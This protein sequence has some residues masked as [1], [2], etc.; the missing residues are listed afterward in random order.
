[1]QATITALL[2]TCVFVGVTASATAQVIYR[3]TTDLPDGG[4]IPDGNAAGWSDT[5]TLSG[6]PAIGLR[7]V[8]VVLSL[9]GGYNGDLYGYL[10]H[11]SGFA[12]LL[13]RVGRTTAASFGYNDAGLN[14]TFDDEAPEVTDIHRYQTVAGYSLTGEAAWRPDARD[15]S[16]LSVLDTDVRGAFL[17]SFV[18]ENPNGEWTL[19]LA[20]LSGGVVSEVTGW[21][22]VLVVPEPEQTAL[23]LGA[24]AYAA[25]RRLRR[26][27]RQDRDL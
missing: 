21:G 4:Q 15:V 13:N 22:L 5:R 24:L 1:M 25:G 17:S 9:A 2:T 14:V 11:G 8:N 26:L 20:D 16:P 23:L 6:L 19:F 18:G 3:F 12:V 7:D 10:S 27:H